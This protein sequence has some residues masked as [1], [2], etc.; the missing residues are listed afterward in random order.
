[1]R[2]K[3]DSAMVAH[4]TG[5]LRI[6]GEFWHVPLLQNTLQKL[7]SQRMLVLGLISFY[8]VK[9]DPAVVQTAVPQ[10]LIGCHLAEPPHTRR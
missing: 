2:L 7:R 3:P 5:M 1:M 9:F 8:I 4:V 10:S 6:L